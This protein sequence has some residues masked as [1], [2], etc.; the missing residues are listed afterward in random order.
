MTYDV[1]PEVKPGDWKGIDIEVPSVSI[2]KADEERELAE[3]RERNAIV[4]D[5]EEAAKVAK[6]DIITVDY[7]ELGDNDVVKAGSEREDFVFEVGTGYNLYKF[8]EDVIGMKK[9]DRKPSKKPSPPTSRTRT[10]PALPAGFPS[11]SS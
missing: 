3:I 11:W 6:G 1:F 8:D 4:V 2:A 7:S 5:K 9:G 10:W